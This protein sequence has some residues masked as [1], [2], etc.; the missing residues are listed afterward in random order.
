MEHTD[1][2]LPFL[3]TANRRRIGIPS[4]TPPTFTLTDC[5]GVAAAVVPAYVMRQDLHGMAFEWC[6]LV[7][8]IVKEL[9]LAA[10]RRLQGGTRSACNNCARRGF[11]NSSG[12][13]R[14]ADQLILD[15]RRLFRDFTTA[16]ASISPRSLYLDEYYDTAGESII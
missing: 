2:S 12:R 7:P 14:C 16:S 8:P 5:S 6:D 4:Y 9:S 11:V 1:E 10:R 3:T 15:T 13:Q